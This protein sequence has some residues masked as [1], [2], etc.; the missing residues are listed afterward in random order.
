MAAHEDAILAPRLECSLCY[1]LMTEPKLLSCTHTYCEDC[2]TR[3]YQ[4]QPW[5]D[6][7]DTLSCPECRQATHV[8]N[9]D[10]STL[11]TNVPLKAM[12]GDL[13]GARSYCSVCDPEEKSRATVYCQTCGEYLCTSCLEAHGRYRKN[14]AHEVASM[15]DIQKGKVKVKSFCHIHLHEEKLWMCTTCNIAIC[16]KCGMLE[17]NTENH[18]IESV[19]DLQKNVKSRVN[20]LQM[21]ANKK[22][23]T[24]NCKSQFVEEEIS[25]VQDA[26]ENKKED[27]EKIYNES[28]QQ[29]TKN[30]D[31]IIEQY[32]IC[33]QKFTKILTNLLDR[34]NIDVSRMNSLSELVGNGVKKLLEGTDVTFHDSLCKDLD[35][36]LKKEYHTNSECSN[37][38]IQME[39]LGFIR[40]SEER[41]LQLGQV[42]GDWVLE[43]HNRISLTAKEVWHIHVLPIGGVAVA[44]DWGM[45]VIYDN[46]EREKITSLTGSKVYRISALSDGRFIVRKAS[47]D[48]TMYAQNEKR[49]R[50]SFSTKSDSKGGG[51]CTDKFNNYV[52]VGYA[53]KRKIDVF[54]PE[55]GDPIKEIPCHGYGPNIIFHMNNSKL[56]LVRDTTTVRLIDEDGFVRGI[57]RKNNLNACPVVLKDDTIII[58]WL[59]GSLLTVDIYTSQLKFVRTI[60]RDFKIRKSSTH[61]HFGEMI[62]GEIVFNDAD[63]LY[64]F[65]KTKIP[66]QDN[67]SQ[68][69]L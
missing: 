29:L 40:H 17:H 39:E 18:A 55:G 1:E 38:S 8:Q 27:I 48:L 35:T 52:Y 50:T 22:V 49:L 64:V 34:T 11:Q 12:V 68:T 36:I 51:L 65:R 43:E 25:K 4:C 24:L 16:L 44:C 59:D 42:T 41:E 2:L 67:I 63:N 33:K 46:V 26:L 66:V 13:Q 21:R 37:I 53:S 57:V 54:K 9:G 19:S 3:L 45:E 7:G 69:T 32:E 6:G 56:L 58:G 23:E 5:G 30:R 31:E 47:T 28:V 61:V 20:S 15:D 60:L 14:A 62:N 10:I